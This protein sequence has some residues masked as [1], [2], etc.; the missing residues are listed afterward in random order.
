MLV[1]DVVLEE[2]FDNE[3]QTF[4]VETSV[5]LHLEHSLVSLSKWESKWEKPFLQS[6]KTTD[7]TL[8]YIRCMTLNDFDEDLY[9]YLSQSNINQIVEYINSSQTATTIN[10]DTPAGPA[11]NTMT[12]E[13]FYYMMVSYQVPFECQHWHLNR[14]MTL[15]RVLHVK[16]QPEKKM[17]RSETLARNREL[18]RKRREQL[19]TTG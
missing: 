8:D 16:N 13:I 1:I 19:K 4:G 7:E 15:L 2:Q 9:A 14:L 6:E 5:E 18:N 3:T 12:S 11:K 17:S 10:E